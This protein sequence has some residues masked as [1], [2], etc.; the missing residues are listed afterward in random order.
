MKKKLKTIIVDDHKIF[1]EGFCSLLE[2]N[3]FR[4]VRVFQNSKKAL[5]YLKKDN[6]TELIFSDVNMPDINGISFV[7]KIFQLSMGSNNFKI[8][9]E[10]KN[11][12][13][14][15]VFNKTKIKAVTPIRALTTKFCL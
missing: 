7:K 12:H 9:K 4:V 13:Q 11:M 2:S 3:N 10:S 8:A 1:G 6:G 5:N 14:N 15:I